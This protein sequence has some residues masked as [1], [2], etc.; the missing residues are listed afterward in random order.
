M[1]YTIEQIKNT[2]VKKGYVWFNDDLNKGFDVN[3]VGI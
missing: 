2:I 3:I 1:S